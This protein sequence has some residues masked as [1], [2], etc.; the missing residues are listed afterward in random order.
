MSGGLEG[1]AG[2]AEVE[3]LKELVDLAVQMKKAGIIDALR[4]L[5]TDYE[6][7]MAVLSNDV[8]LFRLIALASVVLD[9]T[10]R[11]EPEGVQKIKRNSEEAMYCALRSLEELDPS[12]V[13]PVGLGGLLSA[14]RDKD[15][16]T[17]LGLL[18]GLAKNLGACV[19]GSSQEP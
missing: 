9:A 18:V 17:G 6:G 19:R 4:E 12:K 16:Q 13:K 3:A 2:E 10:R 8:A 7:K 5:L 11:L 14:L 15:V 1:I